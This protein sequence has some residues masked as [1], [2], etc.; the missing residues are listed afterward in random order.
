MAV[1]IKILINENLFV[2]DPQQTKLGRKIIKHSILLIDEIGFEKFTF[3]KLA[4]EIPS[5]EAS[6]YRYFVNKHTLLVYLLNWYWEW[7]KYR[8]ET[9]LINLTDPLKKLRIILQII[10]DSAKR[11]NNVDFVD[12]DI[13][14]NIIVTEGTKGYHSKSVDEE[15]KEGFFL[16]YKRLSKKI[17]ENILEINPLFPYPRALATSLIETANNSIYF[18]NHL[19]RLT[20]LKSDS[21][22]FNDDLLEMLEFMALSQIYNHPVEK[23]DKQKERLSSNGKQSNIKKMPS[24][25]IRGYETN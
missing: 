6:I 4:K 1:S 21:P 18:A 25:K 13:L 8:L 10:L 3:K 11:D 17:A 9:Q 5:T 23:K 2:R 15:N 22:N 24:R 16:A 14:H 19:P 12:E 20:D 7:L